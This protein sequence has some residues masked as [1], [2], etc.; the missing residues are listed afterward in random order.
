MTYTVTVIA[1]EEAHTICMTDTE[2]PEALR[3]LLRK[4]TLLAR[5]PGVTDQGEETDSSR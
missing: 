2:M 1:G 4:L 5:R 3:P